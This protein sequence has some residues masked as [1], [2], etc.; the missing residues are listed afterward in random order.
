MIRTIAILLALS[1]VVAAAPRAYAGDNLTLAKKAQVFEFDLQKRFVFDGQVAPKLRLPTQKFPYVTYNMPDDAYMTGIYTGMLAMQYA[2]TKNA[3]TR[4]ALSQAIKALNLLCTVS[5]EKGLLARAAVKISMPFKDDGNWVISKDGKYRWRSDVSSDQMDGVFYGFAVAYDLAANA[6]EKK[7]IRRDA[8]DLAG[9]LLDD[10]LRIIDYDGKPTQWGNYT[11]QYVQH[12]EP[13]NALLLLQI[14]K[15]TAHVTGEKRFEDAYQHY[16]VQEHLAETAIKARHMLNPFIRGAVNHSDDVLLYLAYYPLLSLEKDPALHAQYIASLKRTWNGADGHPGVKPENNPFY[17]FMAK[18]FL[19]D[20][21]DVFAA[22]GTLR[23]FPLDM[24]WNR[25]T[26]AKYEK[27]F[28]FTFDPAPLSPEPGLRDAIPIDRRPKDWSAWVGDPYVRG[29]RTADS[30][31]EYNGLDYL[32]GY[33]MG[34]YIG[35]ITPDQ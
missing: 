4:A 8:A 28:G 5:G 27:Q 34:R 20:G 26:I 15:V 32:M 6:A 13:L 33:W 7:I 22:T 21:S 1:L 25:D 16:A 14:L 31:M 10:H 30:N 2:V 9:R 24:K 19:D 35:V 23:W 12:W 3:K 17:A 29:T 11:L 18:K